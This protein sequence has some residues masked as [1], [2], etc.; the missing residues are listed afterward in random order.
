MEAIEIT[1]HIDNVNKNAILL[2]TKITN[3]DI[4]STT[5]VEAI[6]QI[7]ETAKT[8]QRFCGDFPPTGI[9]L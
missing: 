7:C 3:S 5:K 4:S 2:I 1:T 9:Q 6:A 8:K